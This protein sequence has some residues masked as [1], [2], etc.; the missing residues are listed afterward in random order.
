MP[1]GR[2]RDAIT[3]SKSCRQAKARFAVSPAAPRQLEPIRVAYADPPYPGLARKYYGCAEVDHHELVRRLLEQYPAGWALSTSA[4]ALDDVLAI[5]REL[6]VRPRVNVWARGSRSSRAY[7][8]RNAW[9]PLLT[10]GGRPTLLEP[11]EALDDVLVG[12]GGR[13][14][15]HPGALVGMKPPRFCVWMFEL[16]G[17]GPRD[18]LVDLFPGS[19]AVGRAWTLFASHLE[20]RDASRLEPADVSLVDDLDTSRAPG[21]DASRSTS[22]D[23]SPRAR[24]DTSSAAARDTCRA[25]GRDASREVLDDG[26]ASKSAVC[27]LRATG[28]QRFSS[29]RSE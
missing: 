18:E 17:L 1:G 24:R 13:Q 4:E 16:L 27:E 29:S 26:S 28:S 8:P 12:R 11:G 10:H 5:C 25:A 21:D 9:E 2:R 19:G 3:C 20:D 6:G 7:R 14:H 15:S 22:R 23:A